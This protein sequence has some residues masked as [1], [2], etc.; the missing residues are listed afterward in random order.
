MRIILEK[1]R[2]NKHGSRDKIKNHKNLD[3]KA[4]KIEIKR[5]RIKLKKIIYDKLEL[6]I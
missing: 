6:R 2:H 5:R 4:K 1:T 3:K